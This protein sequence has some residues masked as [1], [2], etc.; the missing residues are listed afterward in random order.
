M[1][2]TL[3]FRRTADGSRGDGLPIACGL[4]SFLT[5]DPEGRGVAKPRALVQAEATGSISRVRHVLAAGRGGFPCPSSFRLHPF[6]LRGAIV[7]SR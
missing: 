4:A 5:R 1:K 3:S 6:F 7:I 2:R